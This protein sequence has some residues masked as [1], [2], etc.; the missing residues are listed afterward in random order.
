M[1]TVQIGRFLEKKF[2]NNLIIVINNSSAFQWAIMCLNRWRNKIRRDIFTMNECLW[3]SEIKIKK[4]NGNVML[5]MSLLILFLHQ[6]RRIIACLKAEE[7]MIT[8]LRLFWNFMFPKTFQII[9]YGQSLF[10]ENLKFV[11]NDV[12]DSC[13]SCFIKKLPIDWFFGD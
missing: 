12:Y 1:K 9:I 8:I 7:S 3:I 10:S 11:K 5:N 13:L 6:F 4:R 2:Q